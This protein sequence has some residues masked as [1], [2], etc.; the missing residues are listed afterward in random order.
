MSYLDETERSP[1]IQPL[2]SKARDRMPVFFI[3]LERIM[4]RDN[5]ATTLTGFELL[6]SASEDQRQEAWKIAREQVPD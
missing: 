4:S 6:S 3:E 5:P 1:A 2:I